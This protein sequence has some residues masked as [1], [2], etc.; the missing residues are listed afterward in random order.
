VEDG[1]KGVFVGRQPILDRNQNLV[2]FELLFRLDQ[3]IATA[4]VTNDLSATANV[5]INAYSQFG[6][7]N[8]LDRQLGFINVDA[9]FLMSDMIFLLPSEHVVIEVL[10]SVTINEELVLRC[11]ELKHKGYKLALDDVV[12]INAAIELLLPIVSVVKV[13]VLA[14]EKA[15]LINIVSALKRWPVQ[16]LAEKVE[17]YEQ[18]NHCLELGFQMFQGFCFAKPE[19]ISG[20][21]A[22]PAELSLLKILAL[23]MS[24]SEI[25]EIEQEFKHQPGLSYNL[26]R[27]V[28]SAACGLP[29]HVNSIRHAI[30][31]WPVLGQN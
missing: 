15:A 1:I 8:I 2:A 27:K 6:I 19:V 17:D 21:S 28:N 14:L 29:N 18:A 24:D 4:D 7:Q 30:V 20:R 3:S 31:K 11:I 26:L 10:E 23:I 22:D 5:I 9:E 12:E 16:L 25:N 13:D